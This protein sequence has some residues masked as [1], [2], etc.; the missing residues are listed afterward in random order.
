MYVAA[1]LL[2]LALRPRL[3]GFRARFYTAMGAVIAWSIAYR[4][5]LVWACKS[6]MPYTIF[7]SSDPAV[8]DG[9]FGAWQPLY[10]YSGARLAPFAVGAIVA[11][12]VLDQKEAGRSAHVFKVVMDMRA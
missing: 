8:V 3:P 9:F 12:L 10:F 6:R 1:P 5:Y 2:L 11:A 4:A 7:G